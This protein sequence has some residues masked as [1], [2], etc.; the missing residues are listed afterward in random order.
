MA[1]SNS[2]Y[3][4]QLQLAGA[5]IADC[6]ILIAPFGEL[7][8]RIGDDGCEVWAGAIRLDACDAVLVRTMPPGSLEQVVLRMD[9][10]LALESLGVPVI[11]R[12]RAVETAVDKFLALVR[13][14]NAGAPIPATRVCQTAEQ[15]LVAFEDLGGDVVVKPIF[16]GE[17]R[18]VCRISDP[19]VAYRVL[20]SLARIQAVLYLQTYLP[21]RGYDIRLLV[22]GDKVWAIKRRH[23]SDWR[24]NL[25]RG[26]VAEVHEATVKELELAQ[27]AAQAVG[28]EFAGVDLLPLTDGRSVILEVN[29]VP[30]WR[31]IVAACGVDI[32]SQLLQHAASRATA[33]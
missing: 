27:R 5:R 21:H 3:A 11:N 13:L 32:A 7:E 15:A 20:T 18:G 30:G 14:Q 1:A 10:L 28:A 2:Y 24:T 33:N 16:G 25:S 23:A 9:G 31:G 26:A 29:A 4:R 8:T 22:L 19:D 12:P 17:G 6:E